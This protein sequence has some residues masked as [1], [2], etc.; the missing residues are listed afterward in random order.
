MELTISGI[1]TIDKAMAIISALS[2]EPL[3]LGEV[4]SVTGFPK[5]TAHRMLMALETHNLVRRDS[6]GRFALGSR[7]IQ[8]GHASA[9][10]HPFVAPSLPLLAALRDR[11]GESVQMYVRDGHERVCVAAFDSP[12][13]LR[14][15]VA[16]GARLPLGVGSAGRLLSADSASQDWAQSV[17]E[18]QPGVASVSAAVR[19]RGGAVVA[20]ISVSGPIERLGT[21]PGDKFGAPVRSTAKQISKRFVI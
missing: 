6:D 13:E 12:H 11:T 19:D 18:R 3:A 17:E 2:V 14:T 8:L 7:W 9:I 21:S 16:P 5:P 1:G 15:I 20:A 4:V 10:V